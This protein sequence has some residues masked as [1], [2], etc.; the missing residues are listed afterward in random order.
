MRPGH[1]Y[2]TFTAR[3][4]R[5]I[6]L[7]ALSMRDLDAA[8]KFVNNLVKERG[9][10]GDLGILLDKRTNRKEER[11]WLARRVAAIGSGAAFSVAAFDGNKLIGNCEVVRQPFQDLRHFGTLGIAIVDGY[12]GIGLGRRMMEVLLRVSER[13]GVDLVELTVLS[14]NRGAVKLYR[15]LGFVRCGFVPA[16]FRRGTRRIDEIVM[17]RRA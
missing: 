7:R 8:V 3:D 16:K 12:R 6:V 4:G 5:R 14:I 13:G 15:N 9:T 2:E 1:V 10:N 11:R 17:Y